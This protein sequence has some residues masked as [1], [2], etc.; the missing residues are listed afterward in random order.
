MTISKAMQFTTFLT[1][2]FR[3]TRCNVGQSRK[4]LLFRPVLERLEDRTVPST[5]KLFPVPTLNSLPSG[6][7][8]GPDGNLWFTESQADKIASI[9]PTTHVIQEFHIPNGLHGPANIITGPDGNLWFTLA[10]RAYVGR[11]NP[12]RHGCT[13]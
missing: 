12:R 5:V 7:T 4:R 11:F 6:I 3:K 13:S 1:R 9:N 10:G 2:R 8:A